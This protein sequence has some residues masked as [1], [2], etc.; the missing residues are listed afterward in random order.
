M[1]GR[2]AGGRPRRAR[3]SSKLRKRLNAQAR[4][5]AHRTGAAVA[6]AE[7][8][9]AEKERQ[10][11]LF[12]PPA[13]G[14]LPPL[15]LLDDPPEQKQGYSEESL[16]AMSRLVELKLKDFNIDVEVQVGIARVR[17]SR[18]SS[19][20]RRR[21]SRSA[22]SPTSRR[23]LRARCRSSACA[24]SRSFPASRSSVSRY[25]TRGASW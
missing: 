8:Q 19:W 16:E 15:S 5:A 11:P 21:A 1:T 23:I 13:A 25:R 2:K 17:S 18:A 14:E 4:Q 24:S 7:R 20:I 6:G 10:V 22:R 3:T 12:D 9:R